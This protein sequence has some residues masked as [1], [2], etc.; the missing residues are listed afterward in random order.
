[1]DV[2]VIGAGAAGCVTALAFARRGAQVLLLEAHPG[3]STRLAGEWL[4]PAGVSVLDSLGLGGLADLPGHPPG[5]GFVV[6]PADD[7]EPVHLEYPDG[8]TALTCDHA[9]LVA[10]LR[11]AAAAHPHIT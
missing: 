11:E 1:M 8:A 4:H 9:R 6:Y 2:A 3:A 5:R 10:A 7:G